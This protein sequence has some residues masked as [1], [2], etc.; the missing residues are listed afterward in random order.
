M[1]RRFFK[2]YCVPRIPRKL[3]K[4]AKYVKRCS[5]PPIIKR[6]VLPYLIIKYD[7]KAKFLIIGRRTKWKVKA[8]WIFIKEY[9]NLLVKMNRLNQRYNIW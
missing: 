4:A 3:K 1:R 9:D 6:Y 8:R 2:R 5:Y 7:E